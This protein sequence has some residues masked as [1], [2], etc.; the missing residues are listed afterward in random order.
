MTHPELSFERTCKEWA[1]GGAGLAREEG[2][3]SC[4]A[5]SLI[6]FGIHASDG[7]IGT[8]ID[9]YFDDATWTVRF[10]AVETGSWFF[11][12]AILLSSSVA[13]LPDW[14][15]RRVSVTVTRKEAEESPDVGTKL[16]V[17]RL[18]ERELGASHGWWLIHTSGWPLDKRVA[19]PLRLM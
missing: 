2:V 18:K 10:L 15:E 8:V 4:N 19:L 14:P 5:I 6:G 11:A 13:R 17:L 16:P 3:M 9:L 7:D 1:I 12:K